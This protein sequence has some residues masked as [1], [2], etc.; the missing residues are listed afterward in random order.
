MSSQVQILTRAASPM[1]GGDLAFSVYL[2]TAIVCTSLVRWVQSLLGLCLFNHLLV[3]DSTERTKSGATH[4]EGW[5]SKEKT[6]RSLVLVW[7][8]HAF[9]EDLLA[10]PQ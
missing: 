7:Q 2:S 4:R 3:L 5:C 8:F 6:K 1:D 9:W 10:A